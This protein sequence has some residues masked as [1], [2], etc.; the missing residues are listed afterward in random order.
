MYAV[1][2]G[3]S[4]KHLSNW[5]SLAFGLGR[6]LIKKLG[7][8]S[9]YTCYYPQCSI[10]AKSNRSGSLVNPSYLV[11][12]QCWSD[13]G[14]NIGLVNFSRRS[15]VVILTLLHWFRVVIIT[16]TTCG[17]ILMSNLP[18]TFSLVLCTCG[19]HDRVDHRLLAPVRICWLRQCFYYVSLDN[20][21]KN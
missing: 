18:N 2:H 9:V 14:L 5:W 15:H 12:G 8:S 10:W 13:C 20:C 21:S 1:D 16:T 3:I 7:S 17:L 19:P 6:Q 11:V 4:N